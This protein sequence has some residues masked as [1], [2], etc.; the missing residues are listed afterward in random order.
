VRFEQGGQ[1]E[2]PAR[3]IGDVGADEQLRHIEVAAQRTR[4]RDTFNA[5]C[6]KP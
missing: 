4:L 6:R 3:Q 1:S 5:D 2:L